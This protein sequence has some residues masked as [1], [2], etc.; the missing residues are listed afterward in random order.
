MD[1]RVDDALLVSNINSDFSFETIRKPSL[2]EKNHARTKRRVLPRS[3]FHLSKKYDNEI[4]LT[5]LEFSCV[6]QSS[7]LSCHT[8]LPISPSKYF[9]LLSLPNQ[10]LCHSTPWM[11]YCH[12]SSRGCQCHMSRGC[13]YTEGTDSC[14]CQSC[15]KQ[16]C[17]HS[18]SPNLH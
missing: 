17:R 7:F 6:L 11:C 8:S 10:H 4:Q 2:A 14:H 1:Q 3:P 18:A 5:V 9:S 12:H 15:W 16:F 13:V